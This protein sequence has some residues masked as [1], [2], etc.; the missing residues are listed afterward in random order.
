MGPW[1][2]RVSITGLRKEL[3]WHTLEQ[4]RLHSRLCLFYKMVNGEVVVTV[5][6]VGL[7]QADERTRTYHRHKFR[8]KG[9]GLGM[10]AR[11]VPAWNQLNPSIAEAQTLDSF[12]SGLDALCP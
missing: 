11:T 6:D 10:V 3:G 1:H 8:Q 4:R 5:S 9:G 2:K 12:K 7:E